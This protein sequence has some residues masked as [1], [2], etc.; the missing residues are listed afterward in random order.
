MK[1]IEDEDR[2]NGSLRQSLSL[3]LQYKQLTGKHCGQC[4]H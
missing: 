1:V 2:F 4:H 3:L